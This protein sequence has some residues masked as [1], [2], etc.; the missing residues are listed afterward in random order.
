MSEKIG[1]A[2]IAIKLRQLIADGTLAPGDVMPSIR[3]IRD[4]YDVTIATANR[5]FGMLKAEGLTVGKP[6]I[7]TVVASQPRV[8]VT[9][10]ARLDRIARTGKAYAPKEKSINHTVTLR[11]CADPDF[12]Q[13]L[14]IELHDEV[15]MRT[16]VFV[17]DDKP[18]VFA[19]SCIH[20]R[21]L[22][23]VEELLQPEPFRR[24]WQEIYTERTGKTV[25]KSPA[26]LGARLAYPSE[27]KV[28]G[29]DAPP[30]ASVP[31]LV[32]VNAFSDEDGP[33]EAWTD[34]YAPNMWR[35]ATA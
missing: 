18:T 5:A 30:G 31:V 17:T 34:V 2:E 7:G 12:A 9:A 11:S 26:R 16:R 33:L 6:G 28:F 23:A 22:G 27:L 25:T 35:T 29:V 20:M 4:K 19:V 13:M 8:A 3:S 1:Y 10:A 21:A 14:G 15:I 24:F 32:E